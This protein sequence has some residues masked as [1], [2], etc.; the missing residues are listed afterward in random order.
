M[1]HA[2][3]ATGTDAVQDHLLHSSAQNLA[4]ESPHRLDVESIWNWNSGNGCMS[5]EDMSFLTY[6]NDLLSLTR[7]TDGLT[8]WL[9][10]F[11]SERLFRLAKVC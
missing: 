1:K 4:F 6:G 9:E 3:I 8:S 2:R 5:R 10:R 7:P 11:V